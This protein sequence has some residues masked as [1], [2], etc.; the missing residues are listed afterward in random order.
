MPT[1]LLTYDAVIADAASRNHTFLEIL[2]ADVRSLSGAARIASGA[3]PRR[4]SKL[5]GPGRVA[6]LSD[7]MESAVDPDHQEGNS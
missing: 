3:S 1:Y 5:D 7:S 6:A 2:K 4:Q